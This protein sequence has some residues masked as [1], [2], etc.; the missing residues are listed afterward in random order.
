M[1]ELQITEQQKLFILKAIWNITTLYDFDNTS[2]KEFKDTY[3]IS[4]AELILI[5]NQLS[6]VLRK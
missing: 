5:T 6:E 3:S 2:E 4:K 1:I